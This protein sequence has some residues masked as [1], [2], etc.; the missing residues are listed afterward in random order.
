MTL[1]HG[2][3]PASIASILHGSQFILANMLCVY[4]GRAA[5]T[6]FRRVPARVTKMTGFIS[7]CTT[8]LTSI[9]HD[10]PPLINEKKKAKGSN[11]LLTLG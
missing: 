1:F 8:I 5:K 2:H 10:V 9:C 6:A 7:H 3:P 11:L 4:L